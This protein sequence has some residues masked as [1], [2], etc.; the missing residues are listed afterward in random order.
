MLDRFGYF[1]TESNGHLS[2]YLAWYRK[3]PEEI[4][5]W[6]ALGSWINGETGGNLRISRESRNWFETD[7]PNFLNEPEKKYCTGERGMAHGSYSVI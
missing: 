1:S 5:K 7:F 6:I 2:E 4:N 3:N